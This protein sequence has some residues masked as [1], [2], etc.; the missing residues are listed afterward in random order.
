MD[1]N[2][3]NYDATANVNAGCVAISGG[4]TDATAF[5]Y[6]SSANTN[7]GSCIA[8]FS[9]CTNSQAFNYDS[10]ANTDDAS[11]EAKVYG[12]TDDTYLEYNSLANTSLDYCVNSI[13][14]G[15]MVSEVPGYSVTNYNADANVED[16]S[17]I[18]EIGGFRMLINVCINPDALNYNE[19]ADPSSSIFN[20]VFDTS[21]NLDIVTSIESPTCQIIPITF[22][23]MDP[24]A[25]NYIL[26]IGDV[27]I[28]VNT[29]DGSCLAVVNG[30]TDS[31]AFNY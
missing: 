15:C 27:M 19:Y 31:T 13:I 10:S 12:C 11:C 6:D 1:S 5:N 14:N 9:G 18:F 7:D 16:G 8:V 22:G 3:F 30:C 23:C 25:F 17:C 2:A 29:D 28:D 4:C 21:T 20:S 26:P 24:L